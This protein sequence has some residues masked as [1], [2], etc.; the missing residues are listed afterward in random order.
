M[1]EKSPFLQGVTMKAVAFV[2]LREEKEQNPEPS[3]PQVF[4]R[5]LLFNSWM[6]KLPNL[7]EFQHM[8]V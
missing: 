1:L 4:T 7:S 6:G 2:S 3:G 5:F 8:H